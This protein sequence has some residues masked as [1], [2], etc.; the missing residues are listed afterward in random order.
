MREVVAFLPVVN[1]D[2]VIV[3]DA[4]LKPL[5][6]KRRWY[7]TKSTYS[8]TPRPFT[9][10]KE[11]GKEKQYRLARLLTKAGP[12]EFPKHLNGNILDC[13]LKNLALVGRR[14]DAF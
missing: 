3:I 1:S 10:A 6:A 7:L 11:E 4:H 14:D 2:K 13:R 12:W 5:L 9:I 8:G